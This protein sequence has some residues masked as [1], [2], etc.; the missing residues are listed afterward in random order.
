MKDIERNIHIF[1]WFS[2]LWLDKNGVKRLRNFWC[3]KILTSKSS[4]PCLL[5]L[6]GPLACSS[7]PIPSHLIPSCLSSYFT[8]LDS[9][10]LMLLL[11]RQFGP[12]YPGAS[13]P[14]KDLRRIWAR[15]R[16]V[17][18]YGLKKYYSKYWSKVSGQLMVCISDIGFSHFSSETNF[19]SPTKWGRG[20][21][22]H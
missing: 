19:D 22:I 16:H 21:L 18:N 10:Q 13:K 3:W 12:Y 4:V 20:C 9:I 1:G 15:G 6:Y 14:D 17:C 8:S 11:S 5:T 7:P 2:W